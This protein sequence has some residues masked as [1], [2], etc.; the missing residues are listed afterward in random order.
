MEHKHMES[1][2]RISDAYDEALEELMSAQ[3][4]SKKAYHAADNET[5]AMY[6]TMARQELD[7]ESKLVEAG[8]RV[9]RSM[10]ADAH[11][12]FMDV[13]WT[14]LKKHLHRWRLDIESKIGTH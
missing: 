4:Y 9:I 12:E 11:R 10:E 7:H 13:L 3:E 14:H 1:I 8:D 5:K 6:M 2:E